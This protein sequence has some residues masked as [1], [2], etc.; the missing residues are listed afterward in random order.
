MACVTSGSSN[1]PFSCFSAAIREDTE[2][3]IDLQ[4]IVS[5]A[6]VSPS[7]SEIP[8]IPCEP[9][10]FPS[11]NLIFPEKEVGS[12]LG[13]SRVSS[14]HVFE[15]IGVVGRK[16]KSW[17]REA[18]ATGREEHARASWAEREMKSMLCRAATSLGSRG[19]ELDIPWI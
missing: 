8:R 13:L 9:I 2:S 15:N 11:P 19:K 6:S 10:L 16:F 3:M 7:Y 4:I 12:N 17:E 14:F 1:V 5:V 18:T